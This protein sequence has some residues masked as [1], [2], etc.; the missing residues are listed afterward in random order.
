CPSPTAASESASAATASCTRRSRATPQEERARERACRA[1]CHAFW[2]PSALAREVEVALE[3]LADALSKIGVGF[4]R[5]DVPERRIER[6]APDRV[7]VHE[8][9]RRHQQELEVRACDALAAP[10][11]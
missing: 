1:A 7:S 10:R 11:A 6:A 4:G 2:P 5:R 9:Q 8:R 3:H